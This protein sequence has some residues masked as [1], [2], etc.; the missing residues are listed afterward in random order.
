MRPRP[1]VTSAPIEARLRQRPRPEQV[2]RGLAG[3]AP[4]GAGG[5]AGAA[6]R[7]GRG[8]CADSRAAD[9][10]GGRGPGTESPRRDGTPFGTP[11]ARQLS[12][13]RSSASGAPWRRAPRV[14]APDVPKPPPPRARGGGR[15]FPRSG[16][17]LA[18]SEGRYTFRG[19]M[20]GNEHLHVAAGSA[21][22]HSLFA[23]QSGIISQK[24]SVPLLSKCLLSTRYVPGTIPGA[25]DTVLNETVG[26]STEGQLA[27]WR[28]RETK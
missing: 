4:R 25:G 19:R 16:W 20:R 24:A 6:R 14:R 11:R 21:K 9:C 12:A 28:G 3:L 1:F 26:V 7:P 8:R 22:C 10:G 2:L 5:R 17:R 15:K 27:V 23:K 18:K 13:A